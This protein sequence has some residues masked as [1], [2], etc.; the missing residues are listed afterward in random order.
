MNYGVH[1][2]SCDQEDQSR[3]Y[4]QTYGVSMSRGAA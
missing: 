4:E 3:Y 1:G 2:G